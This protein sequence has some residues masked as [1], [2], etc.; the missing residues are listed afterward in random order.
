MYE[1]SA[2]AGLTTWVLALAAFAIPLLWFATRSSVLADAVFLL[3]LLSSLTLSCVLLAISATRGDIVVYP[4]GGWPPSLGI[5]YYIDTAGALLLLHSLAVI[6]LIGLY[7]SWYLSGERHNSK[8]RILFYTVFLGLSCGLAG[9]IATGDLFNLFVMIEVTAISAYALVAFHRERGEAIEAALKYAILGALATTIYFIAVVTIYA[10]Y[11]T[12]AMADVALKSRSPDYAT[13][14]TKTYGDI[15]V[16]SVLALALALWSF[17]FK[18][19]LAPNHFWLVDAHPEAPAPV[20]AALSGLIVNIGVYASARLMLTVFGEDSVVE[21]AGLLRL[22]SVSLIALGCIS[23]LLG[24]FMMAIQRDCKRLLAYSTI[25]HIGLLY[26]ALGFAGVSRGDARELA[27]A[28]LVFHL[29]THSLGKSLLFLAMGVAEKMRG[30]RD[31]DVLIGVGRESR[32]IGLSVAVGSLSLLGVPFTAGFFSKLYMYQAFIMGGFEIL[33]V[34][35]IAA[36]AVSAMGYF[37]LVVATISGVE[38]KAERAEVAGDLRVWIPLIVLSAAIIVLP[39]LLYL[40]LSGLLEEAAR[41][42][43]DYEHYASAFQRYLEDYLG[44]LVER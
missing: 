12:L 43:I 31:L 6:L 38:R 29:I 11:G 10:S 42:F 30:S 23:A 14:F 40:G 2:L 7:S 25:S 34:V 20:S 37:K 35:L 24:A 15:A 28:A 17:T 9:C 32:L 13:V 27:V 39:A 22:V 33:S 44:R 18:S 1:T 41:S 3:A 36:S 19:A 5:M 4:F 26:M 16:A 8:R 21:S